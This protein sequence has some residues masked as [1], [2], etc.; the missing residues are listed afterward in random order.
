[1]M[2]LSMDDI[3]RGLLQLYGICLSSMQSPLLHG[4]NISRFLLETRMTISHSIASALGSCMQT[5]TTLAVASSGW[6]IVLPLGQIQFARQLTITVWEPLKASSVSSLAAMRMISENLNLI[7]KS[8]YTSPT[9][10][11]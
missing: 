1:M 9:N 4:L 3:V 11:A 6:K 10:S 5:S 2:A 8:P 7:R